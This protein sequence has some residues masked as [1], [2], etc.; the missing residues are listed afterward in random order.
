MSGYSW[1]WPAMVAILTKGTTHSEITLSYLRN[2]GMVVNPEHP[3][4]LFTL[5][6]LRL[7]VCSDREPS[8]KILCTSA[9]IKSPSHKYL[10]IIC[11]SSVDLLRYNTN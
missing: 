11:S 1:P 4:T 10:R 3:P 6:Y 9:L 8:A 7:R 2:G 5:P